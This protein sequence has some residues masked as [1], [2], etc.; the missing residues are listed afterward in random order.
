VRSVKWVLGLCCVLVAATAMANRVPP[1]TD[2]QIRERLQPFGSL[3]RAG[4]DCATGD[5]AA[6]PVVGVAVPQ[7][8]ESVYDQFCSACHRLGIADAPVLGDT[9]AWAPRLA[10]GMDT[11]WDHTLNGIGA[12]PAKGAC[13]T[14]SDDELRAALDYM[15]GESR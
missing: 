7:S 1:G 4:D 14:C 15:V 3:C 12:M 13:A 5:P 6:S 9:E 10:Q 2:A 8:G 11:L